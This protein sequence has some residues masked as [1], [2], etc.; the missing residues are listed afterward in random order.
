M[1]QA[2]NWGELGCDNASGVGAFG[3]EFGLSSAQCTGIGGRMPRAVQGDKGGIGLLAAQG[4]LYHMDAALA[5]SKRRLIDN[6]YV[7]R[8]A[9]YNRKGNRKDGMRWI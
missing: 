1:A 5:D 6:A 3:V 4:A 9:A 7:R 8:G 2:R